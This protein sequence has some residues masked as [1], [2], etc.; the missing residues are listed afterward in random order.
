M[1]LHEM[2]LQT[3]RKE[4][5]MKK[6]HWT[7]SVALLLSMTCGAMGKAGAVLD[8]LPADSVAFVVVN[9]MN[10][11]GTR[12]DKLLTSMGVGP[13]I[14]IM[15]GGPTSDVSQALTM[16]QTQMKLGEGFDPNGGFAAAI[17]DPAKFGMD[18]PAMVQAEIDGT[19]TATKKDVLS[20]L[21]MIMYLSGSSLQGIF[22]ELEVTTEDGFDVADVDGVSLYAKSVDGYVVMSFNKKALVAALAGPKGVAKVTADE[23]KLVKGGDFSYWINIKALKPTID[24][25]LKIAKTEI[26]KEMKQHQGRGTTMAFGIASGGMNPADLFDLYFKLYET[27]VADIDSGAV[28]ASLKKEGILVEEIITADPKSLL[29]RMLK[30]AESLEGG[31]KLLNSLPSM[32]YVLAV[33]SA[34]PSG[35]AFTE[36][37]E[38]MN[39]VILGSSFYDKFDKKIIEGMVERSKD[40]AGLITECQMVMGGAPEGSGIFGIGV[41]Y[42]TTDSAKLMKMIHREVPTYNELISKLVA[43]EMADKADAPI[44]SI[45]IQKG[46]E[47]IAG[48]NVDVIKVAVPALTNM[49]AS[50]NS[51][52]DKLA[53]ALGDDKFAKDRTF[54]AFL[55]APDKNTVVLTFGGGTAF[56]TQAIKASAGKG[57]I[58]MEA[59]TKSALK[60]LP[61]NPTVIALFNATNLVEAVK[62]GAIVMTGQP[63]PI[64]ITFTGQTPLA[65]AGSIKGNSARA[66]LYIPTSLLVDISRSVMTMMMGGMM[67]SSSQPSGPPP[68]GF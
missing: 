66:G 15:P 46:E 27:V 8:K 43:K 22:T 32:P 44:I 58:A 16:L 29:G 47:K 6:L 24:K 67:G 19:S 61:A 1:R 59:G 55:A 37:S 65:V 35:K 4:K 68:G 45:T 48:V 40:A 62:T 18:I 56:C 2:H 39:K 5:R 53:K 38:K 17:L 30:E 36:F 23:M 33:G 49:A 51:E 52:L 64:A 7:I 50:G 9:D 12:V 11:T 26:D 20:K 31:P 42:K 63:L 60:H 21:P 3:L 54:R 13:M 41:V 28:A 10:A 34:Q 57:P 25:L 14:G